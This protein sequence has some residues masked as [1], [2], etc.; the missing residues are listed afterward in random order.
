MAKPKYMGGMGFRDI[1][2]FNLALLARQAWRILQDPDSLSARVLKAVYFPSNL[3]LE[4]DLGPS[5]SRVWRA[6]VDGKEVLKQGLIRR[7]G[8]G[9]D[10]EVWHSNWLPRDGQLRP[11]CCISDTPPGKVS[12]LINPLTFTWDLQ[13]VDTHFLPMDGE[14]I[15]SIPLFGRRQEDFCAW[16]YEKSGVFSVRSTYRMI[17]QR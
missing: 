1:E 17:V 13:A 8:T 6:I 2:I 3:F 15:R 16:H 11:I 12:E 5:P 9:E 10:T 14:L 4:A 7:I